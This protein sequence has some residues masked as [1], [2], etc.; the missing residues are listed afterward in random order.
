MGAIS[1]NIPLKLAPWL[2]YLGV[3][4]ENRIMALLCRGEELAEETGVENVGAAEEN[5]GV[6]RRNAIRENARN[7]RRRI[8]RNKRLAANIEGARR[9]ICRLSERQK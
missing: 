8:N 1:G 5:N 2:A 6:W 3:A 4:S 9:V 7:G